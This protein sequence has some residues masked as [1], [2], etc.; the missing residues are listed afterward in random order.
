MPS[1]VYR[2]VIKDNI[3]RKARS[4]KQF[5]KKMVQIRFHLPTYRTIIVYTNGDIFWRKPEIFVVKIVKL[6]FFITKLRIL[7]QF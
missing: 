7:L 3:G 2:F 6:N 4:V 5:V 1:S